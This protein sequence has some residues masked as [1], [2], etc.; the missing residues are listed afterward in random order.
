MAQHRDIQ[1]RAQAELDGAV[2]TS[3]LPDLADTDSIP[4]MIATIKETLRWSPALTLG[5]STIQRP[6][7]LITSN[8]GVPH[9]NQEAD[10]YKGAL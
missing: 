9:R 5:N 4:Y 1:K 10:V 8:S 2:P 6:S 7:F 3:R